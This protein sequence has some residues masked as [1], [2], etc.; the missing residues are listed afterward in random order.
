MFQDS[1]LASRDSKIIDAYLLKAPGI[2]SG[3]L[4]GKGWRH[5]SMGRT[6]NSIT[7]K[8]KTGLFTIIRLYL[9]AK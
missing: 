2:I 4:S 8:L 5:K 9:K 3:A 6:L 1:K 7:D